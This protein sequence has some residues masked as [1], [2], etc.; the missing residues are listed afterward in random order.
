M[1]RPTNIVENHSLNTYALRT[2]FERM[3]E[4]CC[5]ALE[6]T[7]SGEKKNDF[8]GTHFVSIFRQFSLN[9]VICERKFLIANATDQST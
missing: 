7:A 2:D 5:N 9:A 3:I 6:R 1:T 8:D 4:D